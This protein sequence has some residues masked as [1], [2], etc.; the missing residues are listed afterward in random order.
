MMRAI[1]K[2]KGWL[3]MKKQIIKRIAM[4]ILS[5]AMLF[6]ILFGATACTNPT[7]DQTD[8]GELITLNVYSQLANWSGMQTGWYAA[9]LED[10][11]GVRINIIPDST[12][13]TFDTLIE[14]GNMG[15]IIVWGDNGEKY[16]QAVELGLL[17]DWEEGDLCEKYG[18]VIWENAQIALETNRKISGNG[19]IHG[20]GYD[21][22]A[23]NKDHRS[24]IYTWDLRWDLYKQ[25]GYPQV[26]DLDDYIEVLKQMKEICPTDENGNETYAVSLWPDW[27]DNMVMYVKAMATAYYGYDEMT[28][29]LYD[30]ATGELYDTLQE[31]GPYLKMLK[32]FNKLYQNNLLDPDSMT[33]T[34]DQMAEKVKRGGTFFSIFNF[35]GSLTYNTEKHIAENKMMLSL[36]PDEASPAVYGMSM[37]GGNRIWS[38]GAHTKYPELCMEI[39]NWL[40]TP[41]GAMSIWYGIKDL[42]WYYDEEGNIHFTDLGLTCRRDPRHDLGGVEWTSPETGKTYQLGAM[43]T[44]GMLQVNNTTWVMDAKN[45]ESNG[46]TYNWE[47]W[48]S[49]MGDPKCELEQSWRDYTGYDYPQDYMNSRNFT[50]IPITSYSMPKRSGEL[51]LKWN[52]IKQAVVKYS[53][54]A[55]YAKSDAEH[56][57][58]VKEMIKNCKEYGYDKILEWSREQ[59]AVRYQLQLEEN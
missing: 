43:F 45:P 24:F 49:M 2:A 58:Q 56:D 44:D 22:A 9:L 7:S 33:Q 21:L 8:K 34:F 25:L 38:I 12:K 53:W 16:K 30:P 11:F 47:F 59:A 15:D 57:Y 55:I 39:L 5:T 41:E 52:Q 40:Y 6:S 27:D 18:P 32:F 1:N 37:L 3:G 17:Y 20:I 14:S 23:S 13:G 46:E 19:K 31:D 50:L 28:M 29:G 48:R 54:R 51:E 35:S 4:L 36:V 42:M 26:K 10:K